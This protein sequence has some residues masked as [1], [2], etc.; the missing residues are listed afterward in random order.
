[1]PG[2]MRALPLTKLTYPDPGLN[3]QPLGH[4]PNTV[5]PGSWVALWYSAQLVT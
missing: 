5:P 4:K 2:L 3:S 1:M